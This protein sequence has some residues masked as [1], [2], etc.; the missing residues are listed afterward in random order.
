M[1]ACEAQLD[2][3][4]TTPSRTHVRTHMGALFVYV[5]PSTLHS[6]APTAANSG[7]QS[8]YSTFSNLAFS[9]LP[10]VGSSKPAVTDGAASSPSTQ[11]GR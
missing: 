3:R 7:R 4:S 8:M 10:V 5:D 2:A 6:N 9:A 11:H 1:R